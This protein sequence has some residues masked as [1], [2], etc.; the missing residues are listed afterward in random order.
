[1]APPQRPWGGAFF[2]FLNLLEHPRRS[3]GDLLF[4]RFV[5]REHVDADGD[6]E[7]HTD[8]DGESHEAL[9]KRTHRRGSH[10]RYYTMG[11]RPSAYLAALL[12]LFF[13][14]A[15]YAQ[16]SFPEQSLWLSD[17]KP[18]VGEKI[19][20]YAVIYN[21]SDSE[22][23]GTLTFMV[24]GKNNGSKD[25]SLDTGESTVVASPW[26]AVE[27]EHT[28]TATFTTG[29]GTEAVATS[30]SVTASV[31]APPSEV[32]QA[33]SEAKNVT[34]QVAATALPVISAIGNNI[35]AATESLRNAGITYLETK[36]EPH[37]SNPAVLGTTTVS[38]VEGFQSTDSGASDSP[39]IVAKALNAAAVGT[40]A[41]FRSFWLFY[42]ILVV[43]LL[44]I[45]RWLYKWAT[46]PRF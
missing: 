9:G 10:I 14:L 29:A 31:D 22:V 46:R 23:S 43:L 24:D 2:L 32:E 20:I 5:F 37:R 19:R 18:T 41:V 4:F 3:G 1:M 16:A 11:M 38:R 25:V 35:Y 7:A 45:F 39:G 15:S 17:T 40:L 36:I 28:F 13:P 8:E 33:V 21:G 34:T 27:G 26:T 42:P 6:A 12:L 30:E 44:L